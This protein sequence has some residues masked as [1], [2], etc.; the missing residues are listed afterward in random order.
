[1]SSTLLHLTVP[2][3][4]AR[5]AV[6][7]ALTE[8]GFT[9]QRAASGSLDVSRGS[10]A[11]T[12]V[13][14]A[15]A[16]RDMHVRFDVHFCAEEGGTVAAFEHSAAGGFVKGGAVGAAKTGEV[17]REAAHLVGT[18]LTLQGLVVGEIPAAA[19]T[20]LETAPD[21]LTGTPS[22]SSPAAS[23]P[24]EEHPA[25]PA[26]DVS[27]TNVVSIVAIVLGFLV[28]I[29]GIIAGA[30]GLAQ[31]K[32]TGEKGRALALTGIIAGS[33][34]TVLSAIAGIAVLFFLVLLG[35]Q[36]SAG[37]GDDSFVAPPSASHGGASAAPDEQ[38]PSD[39]YAL[40]IGECLDDVPQGFV[41]SDNF[42]DCAVPHTYEVF[43][44]FLLPD[45]A[46]PG[47]TA[48]DDA[49]IDGCGAAFAEYIGIDYEA[50]R[51]TSTYLA[52]LEETWAAGDRAVSC[53][54]FDPDGEI[55]GSL[56]G[57]AR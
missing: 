26:D 22:P 33:V 23:F 43:S 13:T 8:Q 37:P 29:G 14:G 18:R 3:D 44:S 6:A 15:F 27:S 5:E 28:P 4:P 41:S 52:P 2:V 20:A 32:R 39:L 40:P 9:V 24:G 25:A 48:V 47:D 12:I 11:T 51:L 54:V 55:T 10:L 31:I 38:A 42:V 50:S 1:M 46:F 56:R 21:P 35:T 19:D 7:A 30:V 16:G 49:A 45:G 36:T 53:L 57:A 34:L 17:T